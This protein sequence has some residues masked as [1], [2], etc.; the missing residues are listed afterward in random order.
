MLGGV[1]GGVHEEESLISGGVFFSSGGIHPKQRLEGLGPKLIPPQL[2]HGGV[3]GG[4]HE[5]DIH[6][7]LEGCGRLPRAAEVSQVGVAG[8]EDGGVGVHSPFSE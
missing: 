3:G 2:S 8:G 6:G 7:K 1:P 4:V 5:D